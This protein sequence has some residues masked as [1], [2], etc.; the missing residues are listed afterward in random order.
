MYSGS[1]LTPW[2]GRLLGA[3]QKLDRVARRHL[4]VLAGTHDA[5]F[6]GIRNILKFE[7]KNGPDGIKRKSPAQNEPWH[8]INPFDAADSEL[9][10]LIAYHYNELVRALTEK[11][12][13]KAAFEAAW[14]SH[15]LVDGLT[16]AHHYPYEAELQK[17]RGGDAVGNPATVV[18]KVLMP[19]G[20][21]KEQI[22][23]NW[24]MW[25]PKGLMSTHGTFEIGIATII[26]PLSFRKWLPLKEDIKEFDEHG[27]VGL[28]QRKVKEI[29][30]MDLYT[31]YYKTGW[32]PS[33]A[34]QVRERL[35]PIILNVVTLAWY[36][37]L[38]DAELARK[39]A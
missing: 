39:Q 2:S 13:T 33:L 26:A 20:N 12:T 28:F 36:G 25:G 5:C 10:D 16:P 27:V 19:G 14:L 22:K 37:A 1:T 11:N 4:E 24:K 8:F 29:A 18:E 6:P 7:G 21:T 32:T 31:R 30:A 15:A 38:R 3:H 35:A 17:L 34:R 9:Y 23:N